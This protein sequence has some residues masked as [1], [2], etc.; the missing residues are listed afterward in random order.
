ML[1]PYARG[2][3]EGIA[4]DA[5]VGFNR[6]NAQGLHLPE[7]GADAGLPAFGL[8]VEH[9]HFDVANLHFRFLPF[10]GCAVSGGIVAD[11]PDLINSAAT[12]GWRP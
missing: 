6:D 7:H 9:V 11:I 2:T 1:C 3:K 10:H 4:A 12:T 8:P 5:F